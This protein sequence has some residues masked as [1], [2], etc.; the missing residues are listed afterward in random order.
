MNQFFLNSQINQK[1]ES[2]NSEILINTSKLE[3]LLQGQLDLAE[4]GLGYEKKFDKITMDK[5]GENGIYERLEDLEYTMDRH[6]HI[7]PVG[8]TFWE[9]LRWLFTGKTISKS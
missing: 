1:I 8:G 5:V 6:S 2:V 4:N 3:T 7:E 9:R